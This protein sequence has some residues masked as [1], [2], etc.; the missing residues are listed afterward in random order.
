MNRPTD[1]KIAILRAGKTQRQIAF[2]TGVSENRL[3]TLVNGWREPRSDERERL[4]RALG[5]PAEQLFSLIA[6]V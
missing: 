5:R 1:L 3:S 6:A 4:A 2:E